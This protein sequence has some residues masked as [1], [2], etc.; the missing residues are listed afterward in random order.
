MVLQIAADF[1]PVKDNFFGNQALTDRQLLL[2]F[3]GVIIVFLH[4][5]PLFIIT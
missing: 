5:A 4:N 3:G 2:F 1:S